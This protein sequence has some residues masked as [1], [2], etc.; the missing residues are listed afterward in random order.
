MDQHENAS[1]TA[2]VDR[3]VR[4]FVDAVAVSTGQAGLLILIASALTVFVC[5][6]LSI[7]TDVT[8]LISERED[9]VE[10]GLLWL[11]AAVVLNGLLR[12]R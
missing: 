4:A 12:R 5:C 6:L 9:P 3:L 1:T 8:S 11:S 2:P 7:V 10:R